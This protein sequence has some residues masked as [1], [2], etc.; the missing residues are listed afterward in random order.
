MDNEV[1]SLVVGKKMD[2]VLFDLPNYLFL[3]YHLGIN[4]V[5]HVIKNGRLV[6]KDG[7][8]SYAP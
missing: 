4:S 1:G 6:V 5:V 3:A 8:L 7:R 2:I